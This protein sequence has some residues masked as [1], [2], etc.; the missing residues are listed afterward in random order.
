[1]R[2]AKEKERM[3]IEMLNKNIGSRIICNRCNVSPNL[4]S[5]IRKKLGGEGP[6]E[7][8]HTRAYRQFEMGKKPLEVAMEL[9]ITEPEVTKHHYGYLRLKGQGNL[10]GLCKMLGPKY[11]DQ[12]RLLH[13]ALTQNGIYPHLY[14]TYV[15]KATRIDNLVSKTQRLNEIN[16]K[17]SKENIEIMGANNRLTGE[18]KTQQLANDFLKEDNETL[19]LEAELLRE[20]KVNAQRD[21]N[22]LIQKRWLVI[23]ST[24]YIRGQF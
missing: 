21:L 12:L 4:V 10:L 18:N 23:N 15:R 1:M 22:D 24:R 11:I 16:S 19:K 20:A 7:A 6:V 13:T 8:M 17:I 14:E 3:V 5:A 9:G 2:T